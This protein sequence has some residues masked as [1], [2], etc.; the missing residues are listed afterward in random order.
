[1]LSEKCEKDILYFAERSGWAM[2]SFMPG[3]F[4]PNSFFFSP[5]RFLCSEITFFFSLNLNI[6]IP[7]FSMKT[8]VADPVPFLPDPDPWI[9][10]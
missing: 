7:C 5:A 3:S 10:P 1:M 2:I 6:C 9:W 8:S 4:L